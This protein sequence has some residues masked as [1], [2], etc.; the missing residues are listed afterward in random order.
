LWRGL[1]GSG[2]LAA[3]GGRGFGLRH[4]QH[5]AGFGAGGA[6]GN[7]QGKQRPGHDGAGEKEVSG[8]HVRPYLQAVRSFDR[9]A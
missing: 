7:E 3:L 8:G 2:A 6:V 1:R 9:T 4:A 5:L